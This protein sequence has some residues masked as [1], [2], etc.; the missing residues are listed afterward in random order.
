MQIR[1]A[2]V[3]I[4]C[5]KKSQHKEFL[6]RQI[7]ELRQ[8]VIDDVLIGHANGRMPVKELKRKA[9][10]IKKYSRRLKILNT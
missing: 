9:K 3:K 2:G 8:E 1:I 4:W 6:W 10:L 5:S 7:A